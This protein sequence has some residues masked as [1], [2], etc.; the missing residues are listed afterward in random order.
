MFCLCAK[1]VDFGLGDEVVWEDIYLRSPLSG[2]GF[3]LFNRGSYPLPSASEKS[4]PA[5]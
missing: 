4:G 3:D 5:K 2:K 1:M